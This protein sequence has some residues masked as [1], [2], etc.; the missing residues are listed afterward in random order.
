MGH[1]G[2]EAGFRAVSVS[3]MQT[4]P[5]QIFSIAQSVRNDISKLPKSVGGGGGGE[6]LGQCIVASTEL[7]KKLQESGVD[8]KVVSGSFV[9]DSGD[10]K[11]EFHCWGEVD[12]KV[13]D[14]TCSQFNDSLDEPMPAVY[15]GERTERYYVPPPLTEKDL[16][17]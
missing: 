15:F 8:A 12:G 13:L 16:A 5:D 3:G 14:I 9:K 11:R 6:L 4:A 17:S 7:A 2:H 1:G 10:K